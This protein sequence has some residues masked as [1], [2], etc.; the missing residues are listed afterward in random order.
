MNKVIQCKKCGGRYNLNDS[1]VCPV[2]KT[3]PEK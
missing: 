1:K 3:E 2:C